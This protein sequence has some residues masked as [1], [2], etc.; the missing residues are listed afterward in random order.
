VGSWRRGD[1]QLAALPRIGKAHQK[2]VDLVQVSERHERE[3]QGLRRVPRINLLS[4]EKVREFVFSAE[5]EKAYFAAAP[6]PLHDATLVLADCGLRVSD[7]LNLKWKSII[8]DPVLP[9]KHNPEGGYPFGCLRITD[10]KTRNAPRV[11]PLTPRLQAMLIARRK[12]NPRVPW[13]FPNTRGTGP[14]LVW[15]LDDQ[16]HQV[17]QKLDLDSE[18]VV[19]SFRHT[20]ATRLGDKGATGVMLMYFLGWGSLTMADRYVHKVA[21]STARTGKLLRS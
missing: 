12:T 4:G 6:Q 15:Q 11:L 3:L 21:G 2:I 20:C 18:C 8:L 16:H 7:C 10:G 14:A 5:Q 1:H 17:R 19:Y 9:P 13:V